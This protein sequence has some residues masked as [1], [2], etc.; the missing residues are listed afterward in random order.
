MLAFLKCVAQ[1]I[2]ENGLRGL[3]GMVPGG[4]FAYDVAKSAL[5][6]YRAG[7]KDAEI[8][9][10][11]QQLASASFEQARQAAVQ[12]AQEVASSAASPDDLINLELYLAQIPAAVRQ[13]QKRPEDPTGTTV[14]ATFALKT[15]DDVLKLLPPKPVRFRPG[16]PLPGRVGW[17]LTEPLGVGGFGEVWLARHPQ[18]TSLARAVKFCHD[19]QARDRDLLHEGRVIERVQAQGNRPHIVP[20]VDAH[21]DGDAPWLMFEY[22]PGGDL[23]DVIHEWQNLSKSE[24]V[25]K[26][27]AALQELA[28]AVG[29]FH[30]LDP[31]VVHRDLKPANILRDKHSGNLRVTDFG[32]GGVMARAVLE[33]ETRGG[34]TRGGRLLSCLRGSYTP[35]YA[36]EQQR[37]GVDDPDPRD[38]VHALGVIGYQMITGHVNR[39]AGPDF[40]D[41]LRDAGVGEDLIALLKSCVKRVPEQRPKDALDLA[42][43]LAA[44]TKQ[45]PPPSPSIRIESLQPQPLTVA[46]GSSAALVVQITRQNFGGP[47]TVAVENLPAALTFQAS[48]IQASGAESQVHLTADQGAASGTASAQI[49]V[50]GNG[51][52]DRAALS[53]QVTAPLPPPPPPPPGGIWPPLVT[54]ALPGNQGRWLVYLETEEL[55]YPGQWWHFSYGRNNNPDPFCITN[56]SGTKI[57]R[58]NCFSRS[59]EIWDRAMGRMPCST[60]RGLF[61]NRD[62][63]VTSFWMP[64]LDRL[65]HTVK[66]GNVLLGHLGHLLSVRL[67]LLNPMRWYP[68]ELHVLPAANCAVETDAYVAAFSAGQNP[69]QRRVELLVEVRRMSLQ[70]SARRNFPAETNRFASSNVG[71]FW[72][73]DLDADKVEVHRQPQGG[74]YTAVSSFGRGQMLNPQAAPAVHIAV[75][76][77]LA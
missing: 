14:P 46:V 69:R 37:D 63:N 48:P 66:V 32:I 15:P 2:V 8:R 22:V 34:M 12:V 31:F 54:A 16:D 75:D 25:T 77:L 9:A 55:P 7:Q 27:V 62:D 3:A 45:P 74:R 44:L 26:A 4:A 1:A 73:I 28:V 19:L 35:L 33:V 24:R 56:A 47:L 6:K 42:E 38:D 65:N 72:V 61:V 17:A 30:R 13:S 70:Y 49:V 58:R 10:D 68:Q 23:G 51:V 64:E 71:E 67:D 20:L 76:D 36:S 5:E 11:I 40:E 52:Q 50:H 41:D 53:V 29:H 43:K 21:L 57:R 60:G 59:Q 18:F 39:G